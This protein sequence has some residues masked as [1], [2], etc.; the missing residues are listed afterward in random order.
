[1]GL[2]DAT[3]TCSPPGLAVLA[4]GA[5]D[6]CLFAPLVGAPLRASDLRQG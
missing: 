1:L 4:A 3:G 6:A 2:A 5:L